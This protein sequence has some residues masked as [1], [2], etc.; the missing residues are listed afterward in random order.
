M[1]SLDTTHEERIKAAAYIRAELLEFLQQSQLAE[2]EQI[3]PKHFIDEQLR[4]ER[5]NA[6][7]LLGLSENVSNGELLDRLELSR[8]LTQNR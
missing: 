7:R 3:Y 4:I 2:S 1:I 5:E 8:V 6:I